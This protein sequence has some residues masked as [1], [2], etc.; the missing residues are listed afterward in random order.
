MEGEEVIDEVGRHAEGE[1]RAD[2][3]TGLENIGHAHAQLAGNCLKDTQSCPV[4]GCGLSQ[5]CEGPA[6]PV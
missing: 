6:K 4:A 5:Q 1:G 2:C 3:D